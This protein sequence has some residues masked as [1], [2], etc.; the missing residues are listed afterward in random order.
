[1]IRLFD[2][3]IRREVA[4]LD[5]IWKFKTDK[6]NAGEEQGW[7]RGLE[8]AEEVAVPSVWNT[9][10]G[11][12]GYEGVSW[13]ER[14]F[15]FSGGTLHL[16]FG[17]V[18][19]E[20]RV[21]LDGE[22]LGSHYGGFSQFDFTVPELEEGYHKL[23][24][25][26]CNSFD[27]QS[28]P[29]VKVDWY[30]YGG[31]IRGIDAEKLLGISVMNQHLEYELDIEKRRAVCK[32][33]LELYN[34]SDEELTSPVTTYLGDRI[35]YA[36]RVSLEPRERREIISDSFTVEDIRLWDVGEPNLYDLF[37][38]TDS[39]DLYD[40]VGFRLV[41]V[42]ERGVYL[43]GK[44]VEIRGV[45]RH[46]EHPDWGFAF[47]P[48]LMKRDIDIALDLGCNAIRGSHYP[49]SQV[50]VDM[51][52]ARGILF[53]SEIPMWGWGFSLSALGDPVVIERGLTM[54]REMVKYYYNHPSIIIWGMHNEIHSEDP[55]SI[56]L[57]KTYY[58]FLKENGGNRVVTYATDKPLEDLCLEYCDLIS[59]NAYHGWYGGTIDH[60]AKFLSDVRE[61]RDKLGYSHKPVIFS[62]FGAAAL[63][64]HHTFDD[65]HWTEEYQARLL[66]HAINLFHLDSMCCGFFIWQ[67]NDAR[68]CL[69][70]GINRAR[71]FNNKGILNEYRKPKAAY[72]A[73][74]ELYRKYRDG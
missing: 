67:M 61:R 71:G 68:T 64:G 15:Y 37:T 5:G 27:K 21:W 47:P 62:E 58:E 18:M 3:H 30:H 52:D 10:L 43:N 8:G 11:L 65:I 12:L 32:I 38:L 70:A 9:E 46:E 4:S 2:E 6:D 33:R 40:R 35:G 26:V 31:I 56:P 63:Y 24:V 55:V 73:V 14:D 72:Y 59:I 45:N 1:M 42:K 51:L 48:A 50:F 69:E 17:A 57:T 13:Y 36:A 7:Y 54:H 49:M 23:S 25:R 29:Q 60:W 20:A 41:E 22:S 16:V 74:R 66:T 19:T 44:Y 34:A 39:D 53:W 28:I